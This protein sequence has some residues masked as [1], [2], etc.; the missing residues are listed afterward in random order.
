MLRQKL[1]ILLLKAPL[2]VMHFLL[3]YVSFDRFTIRCA[4][5]ERSVAFLPGELA[6]LHGVMDPLRGWLLDVSQNIGQSVR[7]LQTG[8]DV[9]VVVRAAD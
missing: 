6:Y 5:R 4:N 2:V 1:A 3:G 9:N 8:K 7:R